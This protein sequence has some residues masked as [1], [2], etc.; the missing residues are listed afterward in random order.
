MIRQ[1]RKPN[2]DLLRA[3]AA[4]IVYLGHLDIFNSHYLFPPF[5]H[6][7][8]QC[9]FLFFALSGYVLSDSGRKLNFTLWCKYRFMRLYPVYFVSLILGL[10]VETLYYIFVGK[11]INFIYLPLCILGIQSLF[12]DNAI[13]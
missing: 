10:F 4:T 2:L 1:N 5:L 3:S 12:N 6:I 9:V 8:K 11:T 7:G 13:H